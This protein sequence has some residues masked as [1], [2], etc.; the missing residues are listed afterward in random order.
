[1]NYKYV[2]EQVQRL[3]ST[4]MRRIANEALRKLN[5][6]LIKSKCAH[7]A[8]PE[9]RGQDKQSNTVESGCGHLQGLKKSNRIDISL[10]T[11]I[12]HMS[13]IIQNCYSTNNPHT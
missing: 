9:I 7:L 6:H 3:Q 2:D 4:D 10:S 5:C 8:S 1:M 13:K 12:E 11:I